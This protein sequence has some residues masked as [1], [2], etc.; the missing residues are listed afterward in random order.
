MTTFE[1]ALSS[2]QSNTRHNP[3]IQ[4]RHPA[5]T[6]NLPESSA[7]TYTSALLRNEGRVYLTLE[8]YRKTRLHRG[9]KE[10]GTTKLVIEA[11]E[12]ALIGRL[13]SN[14]HKLN[15]ADIAMPVE[16]A[17]IKLKMPENCG[18]IEDCRLCLTTRDDSEQGYLH[19]VARRSSDFALV[20]SDSVK[21]EEV[22]GV[23]YSR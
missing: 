7:H 3:K 12:I 4:Q 11:P 8:T 17:D 19:F 6:V 15:Q 20:Y 23:R 9:S 2:Y 5:A 1:T 18:P 10:L 14:L 22:T 13:E 16:A 21:I